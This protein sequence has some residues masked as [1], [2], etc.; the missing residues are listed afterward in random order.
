MKDRAESDLGFDPS[1]LL[2]RL[3]VIP[4]TN[5]EVALVKYL[6]AQ[7][8]KTALA[9]HAGSLKFLYGPSGKQTVASGKDLTSVKTI[10]GTG[11]P[12]TR[13]PGGEEMLK[14]LI[15]QG[16]G[17]ELYP[18]VAGILIDRNYIMAACGVLSRQFPDEARAIL[19]DGLE[20]RP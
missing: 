17:R 11:G 10:I 7:A 1:P 20:V 14:P 4:R 19:M 16:P 2:E 18:K 8:C 12:L 9:R 13:L 3:S 6:A 5:E 15:G